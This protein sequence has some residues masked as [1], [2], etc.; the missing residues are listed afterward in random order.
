[1]EGIG[2]N[3]ITEKNKGEIETQIKPNIQQ[4]K[5][6]SLRKGKTQKMY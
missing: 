1:M 5:Y 3:Y 2:V 6:K 4:Q